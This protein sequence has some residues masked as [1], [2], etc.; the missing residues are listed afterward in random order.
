MAIRSE[1]SLRMLIKAVHL[2]GKTGAV[3]ST[4]VELLS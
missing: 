4:Y 3:Y 2:E 1:L